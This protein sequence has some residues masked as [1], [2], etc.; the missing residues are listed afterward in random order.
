MG[1]LPG[2]ALFSPPR[3]EVDEP[4][5]AHRYS[6]QQRSADKCVRD[7]AVVLESFDRAS[8]FPEN[9]EVGSLGRQSRGQRGIGALAV[10]TGPADA[11]AGKEMGDGLHLCLE[12]DI[13]PR[14]R[15]TG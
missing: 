10:E 7:A 5:R 2:A 12:H 8:P 6:G 14:S 15:C 13:W 11:G 3:P 1:C 9:V 4:H